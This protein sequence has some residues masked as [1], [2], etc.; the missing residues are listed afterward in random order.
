MGRT[1]EIARRFGAYGNADLI[2][3][4]LDQG[5]NTPPTSSLGRWFDAACGL[6]ALRSVCGFEGE[7]AMVLES[8]VTN[9]T[10]LP[11]GW[12]VGEDGVLDLLPLLSALIDRAP[13]D[14]A[15]LFHGTL[16]AALVDWSLPALAAHGLSDIVL[17]GGCIM[18]KVLTES[19]TGT[20]ARH[21][22]IAL[23]SRRVPAND[24]G[25]SLGQA[26][27]AVH[28]PSLK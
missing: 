21:G 22:I 14:G 12:T 20:F 24:G 16:A 4:M 2:V 23:A 6:L 19:L 26:W 17:S 27:V 15:D 28:H 5:L 11:G 9:P 10:I 1:A 8:L 3:R 7:A 18:N 13:A 25:L